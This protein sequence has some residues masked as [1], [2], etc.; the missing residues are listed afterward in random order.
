M[1]WLLYCGITFIIIF[2]AYAKVSIILDDETSGHCFIVGLILSTPSL[3]I[4]AWICWRF[5]Q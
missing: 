1:N 4:W 3:M 5:I 2:I